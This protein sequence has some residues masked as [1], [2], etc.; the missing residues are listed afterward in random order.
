MGIEEEQFRLRPT[1]SQDL[2]EPTRT[3]PSMNP[4]RCLTILAAA[5]LAMPAPS[6]VASSAPHNPFFAMDTALRDGKNRTPTEQAALLKELDYDGFGTSG[7]PGDDFLAAFEKQ[8][9]RVFNTYLTLSFDFAKPGLDP[10]LT[11]LVAR[12][13]GHDTALWVAINSV[14]HDGTRLKTSA[15]EGD[16]TVVPRLREL[17][18]L[19]QASGVKVA[20]YPHTGFWIERVQDALRVAKKVD[21]PNV[22]TTFNLCHW[23]KVEG[24]RDPQP[25][26]RE[27]VPCLFFVS[28]NGADGGETQSMEWDRLIQPLGRGSY[29]VAALLRTLQ[30]LGYAGPVGFQGYGIKGDSREILRQAMDGWRHAH[31]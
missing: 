28:I 4:P 17:A 11:E 14:T 1:A 2:V 6:A 24:D 22:G 27:A 23:L 13:K 19:A 9:L 10:K 5:F 3:I 29:D 31:P 26:L 18:G 25:V 20:L 15:P 16:G 12:L 21:R 30:E 8:G 7:Y